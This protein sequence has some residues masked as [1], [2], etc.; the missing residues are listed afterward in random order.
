MKK[1]LALCLTLFL[2]LCCAFALAEEA[3]SLD[4]LMDEIEAAPKAVAMGELSFEVSA[5][6]QSI[7][8]SRP[9]ISGAANYT[10]AYNIYDSDSVPVNYFY[11]EEARVAA[12]PGYG[13]LFN[14]FVVVTDT[15]TGMTV[16]GNIGWTELDWPHADALTVSKAT[17]T[18]SEDKESVFIDRPEIACRS[19]KVSIAYNIYDDKSRPVNYFYSTLLRV[20]ATPGYDGK[21]NVFIVVTDLVT[22]EQDVQNI[23]WQILGNPITM[24]PE[25]GDIVTFG[26]YPQTAAG[27]DNTPIEWIVA[28]VQEGK[29]LLVSRYALDTKVYHS[30]YSIITWEKCSLRAW[31]NSGFMDRAFSAAEQEAIL[32]TEVDNSRSQGYSNWPTDGGNNTQDKV[33]LLSFAEANKY[34]RVTYDHAY[35]K[36]RLAATDYA[37]EQ[38]VYVTNY[39]TAD[40]GPSCIWWLRSPGKEP[41]TVIFVGGEGAIG[42]WYAEVEG[43]G[44]RPAFWLD[45][46]AEI[47]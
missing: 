37:V 10:I 40:G 30:E 45:L 5:D 9:E 47:F 8:I 6:R 33:F 23:G 44:L 3:F 46:N 35:M 24:P 26:H 34:F 1:A 31:L 21:F 19:G 13:G 22:G 27:T 14:V 16:S 41:H 43:K 39:L 18:L 17:F 2:A 38:G 29:A 12:T 42:D 36:A 11:S 15:D 25:V 32:L 20:A 28:D 7:Y 4:S